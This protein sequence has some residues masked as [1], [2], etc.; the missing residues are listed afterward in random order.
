MP[1]FRLSSTVFLHRESVWP[2]A[3]AAPRPAYVEPDLLC[4]PYG[5]FTL[6]LGGGIQTREELSPPLAR[7]HIGLPLD[8]SPSRLPVLVG[9]V[10]LGWKLAEG[11][12]VE[13][14]R[15]PA[16]RFSRPLAS[17]PSG[18]LLWRKQQDSNLRVPK[19]WRLSKPLVS[20]SHPCFQLAPLSRGLS[21]L[22]PRPRKASSKAGSNRQIERSSPLDQRRR[23]ST[24]PNWWC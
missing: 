5:Q 4:W 7:T 12:G 2:T 19:N 6:K 20:T 13:P 14:L 23:L 15:F 11:G 9:Q 18:T 21:P 24:G 17:Q 16:P 10:R 1:S 22:M 8:R 3:C